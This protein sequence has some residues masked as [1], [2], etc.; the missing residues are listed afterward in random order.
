METNLVCHFILDISA[1]MRYGQREQQKMHYAAQMISALGYA[2]ARQSDKVSLAT[3]DDQVR[4]VVPPSN[5]M[6]QII[7]MAELLD[8][9][10]PLEKT[11]LPQCLVELVGRMRRREIVMIFSDF[12]GD[13]P[14]IE[15]ALQRMRYQRHEIVLFQV[16]HHDELCFQFDGLTR[17]IGLEIPEELLAQPEQ[18]RSRYLQAVGSFNRQLAAICQR[19]RIEHLLVDTSR[20]MGEVLV[21][22]LNQRSLLNRGR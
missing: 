20:N 13:L 9:S 7:R 12:F 5:S 19:N 6:A 15:T 18:I 8:R 22:Y 16:L 11:R 17:F 21:D 10:E 4:G 2:I 14:S 3:F 1:S